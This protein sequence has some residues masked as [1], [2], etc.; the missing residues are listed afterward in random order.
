MGVVTHRTYQLNFI[1]FTSSA[2]SVYIRRSQPFFLK[3]LSLDK[4]SREW[5]LDKKMT[6]LQRQI[7]WLCGK[8]ASGKTFAGDYLQ[9]RGWH[10]VD[11]DL[12]KT[13]DDAA[14][15]KAWAD[16][17]KGYL[18]ASSGESCPGGCWIPYYEYLAGEMERGLGK[19]ASEASF[20]V[21]STYA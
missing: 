12:G 8:Q 5:S 20:A 17:F 3:F 14:V 15:Q 11:G 2:V 1:V 7:V 18:A 10:H 16:L 19:K 21:K 9:T 13:S 4:S 6:N